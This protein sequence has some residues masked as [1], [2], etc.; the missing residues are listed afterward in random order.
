MTQRRPTADATQR[1]GRRSLL[2]QRAF[3]LSTL[4]AV[5]V[6]TV[7]IPAQQLVEQR[8]RLDALRAQISANQQLIKQLQ[9]EVDRW[10]DPAYVKAQARERLHYL[11]PGEVGYVVLEAEQAPVV[12]MLVPSGLSE[13]W[14]RSL[15][16]SMKAAGKTASPTAADD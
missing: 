12:Q 8:G 11:M 14:Y 5:I 15:F 6:V 3:I 10:S 7:A 2:T 1:V 13:P 4:T 9:A 16:N